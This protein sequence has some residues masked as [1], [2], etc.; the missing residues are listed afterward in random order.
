MACGLP[1]IFLDPE[2]G[3]ALL[4]TDLP[5]D[6]STEDIHWCWPS[7]RLMGAREKCNT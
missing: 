1:V 2:L 4:H 5:S 3:A 6:L 7:F